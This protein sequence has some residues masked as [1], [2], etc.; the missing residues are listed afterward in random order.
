MLFKKSTV[1]AVLTF[2]PAMAF[3]KN[4]L[5]G[6]AS[7]ASSFYC[8]LVSCRVSMLMDF[9]AFPSIVGSWSDWQL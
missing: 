7:M 8:L 6:S 1:V 4:Q 5:R 3:A 2:L 9:S